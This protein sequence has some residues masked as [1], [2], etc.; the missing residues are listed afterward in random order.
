MDWYSENWRRKSSAGGTHKSRGRIERRWKCITYPLDRYRLVPLP[1]TIGKRNRGNHLQFT[2]LYNYVGQEFDQHYTGKRAKPRKESLRLAKQKLLP[3]T[4][5]ITLVKPRDSQ[6]RTNIEDPLV[7]W[8]PFT[9]PNLGK[10][11]INTATKYRELLTIP[12]IGLV[13]NML[14]AFTRNLQGRKQAS[15]IM[16]NIP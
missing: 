1:S 16:T 3:P 7:H 8:E 12:D 6:K 14:L 10:T 9:P 11:A 15:G 13:T 4:S 5:P 2:E